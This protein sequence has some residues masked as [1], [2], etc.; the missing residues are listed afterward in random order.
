MENDFLAPKLITVIRSCKT[1]EQVFVAAKYAELVH[2]RR[3]RLY[4]EFHYLVWEARALSW[5][6]L[7]LQLKTIKQ[8]ALI[9][10]QNG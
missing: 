9:G 7:D 2:K 3:K 6:L 5:H 10:G 4:P 8:Q 1:R